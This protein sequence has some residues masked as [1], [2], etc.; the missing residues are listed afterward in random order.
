M[1]QT[2]GFPLKTLKPQPLP[3][4]HALRITDD[5]AP[6]AISDELSFDV[7]AVGV[8]H[9]PFTEPYMLTPIVRRA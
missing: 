5:V 2:S 9:Q 4:A 1:D 6:L 8:R 3:P 7:E